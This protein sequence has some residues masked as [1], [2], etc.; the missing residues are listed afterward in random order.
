MGYDNTNSGVLFVNEDKQG[1]QPDYKGKIDIDGRELE[2]A[3]WKRQS[4]RDGKTFLSL[5]VQEPRQRNVESLDEYR[6]AAQPVSADP[7]APFDNTLGDIDDE[8]PF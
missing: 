6:D 1:K 4:K 5:K 2:L 3:G 7:A 8:I